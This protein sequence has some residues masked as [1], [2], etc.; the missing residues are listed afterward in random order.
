MYTSCTTS[1]CVCI[2]CKFFFLLRAKSGDDAML[3]P[4]VV[5]HEAVKNVTPVMGTS[6]VRRSGRTYKV[7]QRCVCHVTVSVCHVTVSVC[8]VTVSV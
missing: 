3:D 1:H 6:I 7:Q 4:M 8:H 5:F 2:G